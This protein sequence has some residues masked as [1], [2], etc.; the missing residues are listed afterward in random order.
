MSENE[1]VGADGEEVKYPRPKILMETWEY[2]VLP[3]MVASRLDP[4]KPQPGYDKDLL[5]EMGAD[6]WEM[7]GATPMFTIMKRPT[8]KKAVQIGHD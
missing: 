1:I 3:N 8:G 6:G 7:A 5:D 2:L 4:Q